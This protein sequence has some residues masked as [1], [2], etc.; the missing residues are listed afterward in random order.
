MRAGNARAGTLGAEREEADA[1]HQNIWLS[2]NQRVRDHE[3]GSSLLGR[4][5]ESSS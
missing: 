1:D 5:L 4:D 2:M 3:P